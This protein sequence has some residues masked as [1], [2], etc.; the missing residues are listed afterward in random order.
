MLL[1]PDDAPPF[2]VHA[3]KGRSRFVLLG[4][5]AG[6]RVPVALSS[7]GLPQ[8]ELDRHIGWDIGIE[9]VAAALSPLLDAVA[10]VQTYSRLV[11]DCNRPLGVPTSIPGTSDGTLVPENQDVGPA[12][13]A[14]RA[15]AIFTPYHD[16]IA[17]ELDARAAEQPIVISLHSFTPVM[18]GF[19][20]P[21]HAGVLY[22]RD[23]R[24]SLALKA[25]LE[26]EPGLVVGNN[27]PYAVSDT[28]DYAIPVHGEQRGLHHVGLEIRQDLI[29]HEAGQLE[30]A[31]RLARL[32]RALEP[33]F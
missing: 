10:I 32:L 13:A 25:A 19:V 9:K 6:Q 20:R 16:R 22:G 15:A 4:D 28:T 29:G 23:A 24:F 31:E 30:W 21:W 17:R 5:H 27:E 12:A 2:A 3:P 33:S 11:I 18:N 7:L 1:G 26:T 8:S 14:E